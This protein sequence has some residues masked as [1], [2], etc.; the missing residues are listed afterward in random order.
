MCSVLVKIIVVD[1]LKF[2]YC[3]SNMGKITGLLSEMQTES[4]VGMLIL[5]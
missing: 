4:L 3:W 5:Y 1:Y 2:Y